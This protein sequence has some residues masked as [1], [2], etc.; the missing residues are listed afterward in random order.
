MT[1]F[2]FDGRL[3]IVDCGVLFPEDD[4]P[5]VDLIL[6]DFDYI[7]DRLDDI[8]ALVLTHGHE[9][10]IGAV[11]VPAARAR[12]HPDLRLPA[13]ARAARGQA[14]GA[15]D[16]AVHRSRSAR[17]RREQARPVR[18]ASSS[19]STTRSPTRWP[20]PSARPRA[21][22]RAHRRLQDGPAAARRPHHRPARPSPGSAKR[23]STCSSSTPPTPRSP[24]SCRPSATSPRCSTGCSP[25]RAAD[26]RRP[27]S[28]RTCTASSRSSTPPTR[29][30][31]RS[32]S[33]AARWCATW[34][35]PA[36][37]ATCASRGGLVVDCR[38][39]RRAARR[40]GR[41]GL[42]RLAGR[43]DGGAVADGQPRPPDPRRRRRH[44]HPGVLAHPGQR[45]RRLPR[46][47]RPD[48][49]GRATSSTRAT[50][51][52]T[53]R[54]HASAGEL[55]YFYNIVK[56]RNVMPVHGEWRHLRAN[57]ELAIR[58]GVPA[59]GSSSPR[60]A[61]SSTWSTAW[62]GSS[63]AVPCG[64][65]YVDGS[66]VGDITEASLK[67]RRIL[68]D[69]GFI[70]VF[71]AVD[72]DDRQGRRRP[73]DPRP[74]LRRGRRRSSTRSCPRIDA[75]LEDALPR[76]RHRHAP[77]AAGRPPGGREVGQRAPRRRPMIV[78]VVVEV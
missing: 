42:H 58:T 9:D 44:G 23:A 18:A 31:A 14:A 32:P 22:R 67:D 24:A 55:L 1:V 25:G 41:A 30:A 53:S 76:G 35:S 39:A 8:D 29:T 7:R 4:Q 50:P 60:T 15:P 36:T 38:R 49:L 78:P 6:P 51:W 20:S 71:V 19:R 26:H 45:E 65:V 63:G 3:L 47:Q 34:A 16:H 40:R 72:V 37:S 66:S 68:G 64:Y 75:A 12:R 21:A 33:S 74:R 46:D 2:E 5:G 77:A 27:A 17:G 69:E 54:G 11:P 43:A 10:H 57:A 52:C 13:D 28:P 62:P 59:S 48:P 73:G 56:P 70:S 61:S